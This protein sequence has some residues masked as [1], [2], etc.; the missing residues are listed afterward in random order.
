MTVWEWG[1]LPREKIL[2]NRKEVRG[3]NSR[4][5]GS[6]LDDVAKELQK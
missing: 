1:S 5:E 2:A 4:T 3:W 6:S